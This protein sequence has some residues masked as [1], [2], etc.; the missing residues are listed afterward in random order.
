VV[1]RVLTFQLIGVFPDLQLDFFF[2]RAVI[3]FNF[4]I[5]LGMVGRSQDMPDAFLLQI[6]S[7]CL[8]AGAK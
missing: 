8:T 1:G 5:G 7:K 6:L 3:P 4:S 2:Q